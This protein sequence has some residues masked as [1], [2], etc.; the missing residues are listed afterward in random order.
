MNGAVVCDSHHRKTR[1]VGEAAGKVRPRVVITTILELPE[2]APPERLESREK[3]DIAAGRKL[4]DLAR[5]EG[6]D[7]LERHLWVDGKGLKGP[8][9]D[10]GIEQTTEFTR[11]V[12]RGI[13]V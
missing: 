10:D 7:A 8:R 13:G 4:A 5:S 12:L 11:D 6:L 1:H 3:Y 9:A 2:T